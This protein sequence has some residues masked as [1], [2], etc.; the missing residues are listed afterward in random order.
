MSANC[1]CRGELSANFVYRGRMS[2]SC[3]SSQRNVSANVF[4]PREAATCKLYVSSLVGMTP[5]SISPWR[6]ICNGGFFWSWMSDRLTSTS[7]TEEWP[8]TIS[9]GS[10]VATYCKSQQGLGCYVSLN[11]KS[12]PLATVACCYTGKVRV[13]FTESYSYLKFS[14]IQP[15]WNDRKL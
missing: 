9:R 10:M 13:C 6:K 8:L 4:Y 3:I 15:R 5:G 7:I 12:W 14:G 1:V 2:D 11:C